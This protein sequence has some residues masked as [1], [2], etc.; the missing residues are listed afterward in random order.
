MARGWE[1]KSIEQ[2]Q[3]DLMDGSRSQ[4]PRLSPVQQKENRLRQGLV[5]TRKRLLDQLQSAA[6]PAH[7][8][9]L[10][11]SLAE[12]DKQLSSFEPVAKPPAQK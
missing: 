3:A 8:Q 12:I 7:R 1:S 11:Q 4:G 2:Q 5:L 10:E 9:M 6:R